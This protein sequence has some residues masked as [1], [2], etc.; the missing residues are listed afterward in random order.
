MAGDARACTIV[1][2]WPKKEDLVGI[3]TDAA[4]RY[5]GAGYEPAY[6][7]ISAAEDFTDYERQGLLWVAVINARAVGF[8]VVDAYGDIDHL[9]EID[10]L[11]ECQGR[12]VGAALITAVIDGAHARGKN[13]VTLRTFRTTPWSI[14]LYAKLGFREWEPSPVP[15]WLK[16]V[17]AEEQA[18]GLRAEERLS[19]RLALA[20]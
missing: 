8:A 19:M 11:R 7:A 10:V 14:G 12:G 9:E 16:A 15:E 2:T 18:M 6:W 17:M 13:A 4:G 1:R 20:R 3:E 5:R